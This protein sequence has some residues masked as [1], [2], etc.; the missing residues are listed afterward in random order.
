MTPP[1]DQNITRLLRDARE[2]RAGAAES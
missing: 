2:G 1:D